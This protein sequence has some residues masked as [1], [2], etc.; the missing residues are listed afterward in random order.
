M[1]LSNGRWKN[2]VHRVSESPNSE[3]DGDQMTL[4]RY[5][6]PFFVTPDPATVVEA[7]PGCWSEEVAKKWKPISAGDYRKRKRE[8]V[9][10]LIRND[11]I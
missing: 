1:R 7:L 5:G 10:V 8:A 2:A 9:Y 4:A 3:S 11:D 6:M